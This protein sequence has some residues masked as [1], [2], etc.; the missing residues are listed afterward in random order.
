M[1]LL[2][3]Y[4]IP[5]TPPPDQLGTNSIGS[6]GGA[7]LPGVPGIPAAGAVGVG[8]DGVPMFPNYNNRGLPAATSCEIDRCSAHSGKGR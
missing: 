2:T 7:G 3:V 8:I 6:T 4:K 5:L 1:D